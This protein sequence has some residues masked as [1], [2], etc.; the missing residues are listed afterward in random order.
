MKKNFVTAILMTIATTILLGIIY[1]LVVTG[2]AK[3]FFPDKA[4]GQL[5]VRDGE[6]AG[7]THHRTGFHQPR[8]L[9]LS[10]VGSREW[11]RCRQL[12][13]LTVRSHQPEAD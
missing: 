8:V 6:G 13:R 1:P 11:L 5:I 7:L 2:L 4:N 9:L 12:Q 10:S 3:L